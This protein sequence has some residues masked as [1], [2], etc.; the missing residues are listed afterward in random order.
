MRVDTGHI[1]ILTANK[2]AATNLLPSL[3]VLALTVITAKESLLGSYA[4]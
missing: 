4:F 3:P 2:S 1:F